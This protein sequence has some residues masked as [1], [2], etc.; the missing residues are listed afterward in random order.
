MAAMRGL[1]PDPEDCPHPA[2]ARERVSEG[3]FIKT[4]CTICDTEIE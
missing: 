3:A 2:E 1:G 4:V